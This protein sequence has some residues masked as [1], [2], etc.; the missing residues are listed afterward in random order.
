MSCINTVSVSKIKVEEKGRKVV[1][2]NPD[3]L[4]YKRGKID[5]CLVTDGIRADYFVSGEGHIVFIELKGCD[6]DHAA[7]QLMAAASHANVKPYLEE[8][9][10]FLILCTRYPRADTTI[11]R[12]ME[13][14]KKKYKAKFRIMTNQREIE[15]SRF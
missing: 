11:Q 5:G 6:V 2:L 1:F 10:C 7:R 8:K 14:A 15:I 4:T 9:I 3:N 12:M 13:L